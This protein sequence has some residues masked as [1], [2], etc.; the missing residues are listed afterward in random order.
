[1]AADFG[2]ALDIFSPSGEVYRG[3]IN[4]INWETTVGYTCDEWHAPYV[5]GR[6]YAFL[7]RPENVIQAVQ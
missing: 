4:F 5:R 2:N 1:M 7:A 6:S 3:D